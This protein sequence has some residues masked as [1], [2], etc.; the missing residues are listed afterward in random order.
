MPNIPE[1]IQYLD[2]MVEGQYPNGPTPERI[3]RALET[4]KLDLVILQSQLGVSP[5]TQER[6]EIPEN[7]ID[8]SV[9]RLRRSLEKLA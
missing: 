6:Q 4:I 3:R 8:F 7:V 5:L 1:I 9:H 2:R